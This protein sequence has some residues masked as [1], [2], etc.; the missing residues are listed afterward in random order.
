MLPIVEEARNHDLV[1]LGMR[2]EPL[3]RSL[4]GAVPHQI[5]TR[6]ECPSV[7]TKTSVGQRKR[8]QLAGSSAK[9]LENTGPAGP[10][11]L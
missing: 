8:F 1:I 2:D 10:T 4:F 11:E 5:A 7:L 6:V 3:L 9:S